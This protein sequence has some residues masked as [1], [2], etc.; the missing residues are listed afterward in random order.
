MSEMGRRFLELSED[1]RER[2]RVE[3]QLYEAIK[4]LDDFLQVPADERRH[5][6]TLQALDNRI[7][8]FFRHNDFDDILPVHQHMR[9]TPTIDYRDPDAF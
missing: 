2:F 4:L 3:G 5:T 6:Q 8:R 9:D 1:A 7:E